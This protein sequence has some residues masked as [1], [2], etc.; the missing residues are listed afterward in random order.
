[1]TEDEGRAPVY[2]L[3]P[4]GAKRRFRAA[5]S[6]R[7]ISMTDLFIEWVEQNTT[8]DADASVAS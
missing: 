5:A 6:G 3:V 4:A 1:M 2:L 7:G 8:E